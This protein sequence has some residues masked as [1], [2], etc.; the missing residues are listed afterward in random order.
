MIQGEILSPAAFSHLNF[1]ERKSSSPYDQLLQ[2][3][4]DAPKGSLLRVGSVK[5]RVS[6]TAR[7]KKKGVRLQFA[8]DGGKLYVRIAGTGDLR[9]AAIP[10]SGVARKDDPTQ[11]LEVS[12]AQSGAILRAMAKGFSTP[13]S[14]SDEIKR[15]GVELNGMQTLHTLEAMQKARLVT[16]VRNRWVMTDKAA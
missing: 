14:I 10:A 3:L 2:Q 12:P 9:P 1:S 15:N 11:T 5:A 13:T 7:A 8:E 6:L 4:L 16:C